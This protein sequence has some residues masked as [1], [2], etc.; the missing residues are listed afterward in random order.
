MR[1]YFKSVATA[2]VL[3][4][5][6][7]M[8]IADEAGTK[9]IKSI[10][11][12]TDQGEILA[13]DAPEGKLKNISFVSHSD[14]WSIHQGDVRLHDGRL[15][16]HAFTL[17]YGPFSDHAGRQRVVTVLNV[18]I[19]FTV[20]K[21]GILIYDEGRIE[22]DFFSGG[23]ASVDLWREKASDQPIEHVEI[24]QAR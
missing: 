16:L 13:I 3:S 11:L 5:L 17:T 18:P 24:K 20:K 2:I 8:L 12:V 6:P 23:A 9:Q 15:A 14:K 4:L 19:V 21:N 22:V 7:Q 10:S 1:I